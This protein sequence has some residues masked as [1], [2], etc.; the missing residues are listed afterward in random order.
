MHNL[1]LNLLPF[2]AGIP[3]LMGTPEVS[4]DPTKLRASV[5]K[6][7]KLSLVL[8]FFVNLYK[9]PLLAELV[10][11]PFTALVGGLLAVA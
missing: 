4:N 10:F 6:N 9:M 11:V 5:A 7:F 2:V 3:T 8:D 1:A